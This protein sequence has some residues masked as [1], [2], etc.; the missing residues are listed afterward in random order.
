MKP[1]GFIFLSR[2]V[3]WATGLSVLPNTASI[4][5]MYS[6][7][8]ILTIIEPSAGEEPVNGAN[9]PPSWLSDA[10]VALNI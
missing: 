8:S 10:I 6:P 2:C 7:S 3:I 4:F 5:P 9:R 1:S